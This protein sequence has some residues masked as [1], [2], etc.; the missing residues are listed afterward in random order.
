LRKNKEGTGLKGKP[1]VDEYEKIYAGRS[2]KWRRN[3]YR[4]GT[5]KNGRVG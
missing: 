4:F 5:I 3:H 2:G 1:D